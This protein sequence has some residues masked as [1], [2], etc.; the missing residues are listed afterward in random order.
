MFALCLLRLFQLYFTF[1][2]MLLMLFDYWITK[3]SKIRNILYLYLYTDILIFI[4]FL[5]EA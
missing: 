1:R 4:Y 5:A 3:H 2:S